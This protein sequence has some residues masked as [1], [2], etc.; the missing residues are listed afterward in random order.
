MMLASPTGSRREAGGAQLL[1]LVIVLGACGVGAWN[2]R[3][4]LDAE[5]AARAARPLAGYAT[6]DLEA[7]AEAYE[8]EIAAFE[9]RY[10]QR[11]AKRVE[12]RDRGY[13]DEQVG[14]LEKVQ[15]HARGTREAGAQVAEREAA[16]REV[17]AELAARGSERTDWEVHLERLTR[18]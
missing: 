11:R 5:H 12:A 8:G 4:N 15:R 3:R 6:Q 10:Q 17:E 13:F 14:E 7:L 16:L 9:A 1:L 18:F 2:Y